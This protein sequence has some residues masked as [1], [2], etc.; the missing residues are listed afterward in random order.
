MPKFVNANIT[1]GRAKTDEAVKDL[2]TPDKRVGKMIPLDEIRANPNQPRKHFDE[3]ALEEL[4]ESIRRHGLINPVTVDEDGVIIA[5]ERRFR[6]CAMLGM[7][8]VPAIRMHGSMELSL[9]EN[10]QRLDLHPLEEAVGYQALVDAGNTHEQIAARIGKD[11]SVVSHS[12]RLLDLPADIQAECVTSHNVTKDQLL[13]VLSASSRDDQWAVWTA[14]KN[15]KS[16][17]AIRRDR[18]A[19]QQKKTLST[20]MFIN[21]V[22][23]IEEHTPDVALRNTSAREKK[24]LQEHLTNAISLL[25]SMLHDLQ[26]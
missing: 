24:Q 22:K 26:R 20:R 13:Q 15:G 25:Q 14:I 3:A 1:S 7:K 16:A 10:L 21:R 11:R 23:A 17:R 2:I 8:E 6:A 18:K 9:V 19:N 12:L 4:A 5:G